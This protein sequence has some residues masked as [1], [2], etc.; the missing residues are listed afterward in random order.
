[1]PDRISYSRNISQSE[2]SYNESLHLEDDGYTIYL[3]GTGMSLFGKSNRVEALTN[4]GASELFWGMFI[5][6][7]QKNMKGE[8]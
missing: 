2:N 4:E 3:R 1:M 8:Y 5:E 7:L 6:S